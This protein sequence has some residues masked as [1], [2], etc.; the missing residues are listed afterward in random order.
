MRPKIKAIYPVYKSGEKKFRIGAEL[1]VTGEIE[2]EDGCLNYCVSLMNGKRNTEEIFHALKKRFSYVTI[3]DVKAAIID[4][5]KE[6]YLEVGE[7]SPDTDPSSSDLERYQGNI[8]YLSHF[9]SIKNNK[10]DIH[11]KLKNASVCLL[12]LGGGGSNILLNLA[13][14][15][16]ETIVAVDKDQV[17]LS[18]LNRQILYSVQDIGKN[19][20]DAAESR[21]R[22]F[23]PDVELEV[24]CEKISSSERVKTIAQKSDLVIC[25]VDEPHFQIFRWV[26]QAILGL[27]IPCFFMGSQVTKGRVF[28][29]F[30]RKSGCI[31]CLSL[32]FLRNDPLFEDQFWGFRHSNFKPVPLTTLSNILMLSNIVSTEAMNYLTGINPCL[33]EGKMY[34]VDYTKYVSHVLFEWPRYS[35]CPACGNGNYQDYSFFTKLDDECSKS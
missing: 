6:K 7:K 24:H 13:A 34:E 11:S 23:N 10:Y 21:I 29:V 12:G 14:L 15:G 27:G 30:P 28:G 25:A 1:G 22:S 18:N 3:K 16:I 4:L 35:D 5:D 32:Y 31:D 33:T 9:C 20:S 8:N 17:D 19:K 26:N 2:D